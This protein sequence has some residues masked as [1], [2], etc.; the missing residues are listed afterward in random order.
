MQRMDEWSG[1]KSAER[2]R[3]CI[4]MRV[5]NVVSI[6]LTNDLS[7]LG[8]VQKRFVLRSVRLPQST[9]HEGN[10]TGVR[11]RIAGCVEGYLMAH[12]NELSG[13]A[14]DDSLGAPVFR[15]RNAF[16]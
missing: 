2:K 16:D 8:E 15:W 12:P 3:E 11:A 14:G 4:E 9:L 1:G 10:E 7:K 6:R 13:E 5:N